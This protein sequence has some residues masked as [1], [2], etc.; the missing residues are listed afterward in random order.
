MK[1]LMVTVW[2]MGGRKA[3]N[4]NALDAINYGGAK[5]TRSEVG[6]FDD[7]VCDNCITLTM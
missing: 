3:T 1:L 2:L 7:K 4:F 5:I 6:A